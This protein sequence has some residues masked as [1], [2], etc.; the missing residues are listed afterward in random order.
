MTLVA[1]TDRPKLSERYATA[2]NSTGLG[3]KPETFRSDSDVLGAYGLA[4][5]ALQERRGA[6]PASPLAVPLERMLMGGDDRAALGLVRILTAMIWR[7]SRGYRE[8][9]MTYRQ[10]E[11]MAKGCLAWVRQGRCDPCGGLGYERIAGTTHLSTRECQHCEGS[12]KRPLEK[13]WP[14]AYRDLV[15]WTVS[16]LERALGIAGPEAMEKLAPRLDL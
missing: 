11:D 3:S 6:R 15:R 14:K 2:V 9:R 5:K 7:Q 10:A 1:M 8:V 4:D 13:E 16:E 12:G